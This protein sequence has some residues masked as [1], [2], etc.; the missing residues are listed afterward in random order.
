MVNIGDGTSPKSSKE[1]NYFNEKIAFSRLMVYT[2]FYSLLF[3]SISVQLNCHVLCFIAELLWKVQPRGL[4]DSITVFMLPKDSHHNNKRWWWRHALHWICWG[5]LSAFAGWWK[6][7]IRVLETVVLRSG[8]SN[9]LRMRYSVCLQ[10]LLSG[11]R[12]RLDYVQA[13]FCGIIKLLWFYGWD[14]YLMVLMRSC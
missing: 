8:R 4:Q 13:L 12:E 9:S 2:T 6:G 10:L 1:N 11:V 5:R 7:H 14:F 3:F